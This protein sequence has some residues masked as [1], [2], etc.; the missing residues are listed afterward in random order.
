VKA[1][2]EQDYR[3]ALAIYSL[4]SNSKLPEIKQKDNESVIQYVIRCAKILLEK[5]PK[6]MF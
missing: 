5:N 3:V 1:Q 2:L 4:F 6:Q